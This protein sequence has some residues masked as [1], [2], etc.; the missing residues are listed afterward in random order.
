MYAATLDSSQQTTSG[1]LELRAKNGSML[2]SRGSERKLSSAPRYGACTCIR[3]T[4]VL[5]CVLARWSLQVH[6]LEYMCTVLS[7]RCQLVTEGGCNTMLC[8]VLCLSI[9]Q[10]WTVS[11]SRGITLSIFRDAHS[12]PFAELQAESAQC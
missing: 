7:G 9:S 3:G 6:V 5:H 4:A 11:L 12:C 8:L 2:I 1:G 10:L